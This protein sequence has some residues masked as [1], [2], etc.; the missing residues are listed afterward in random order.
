MNED[1]EQLV[2]D[3]LA[4]VLEAAQFLGLSRSKLYAEMDAGRLPYCKF[5]A[6]ARRIPW[7]AVR[8]FAEESLVLA[9]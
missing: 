8:A 6:R 5:G 3:G 1:R 4:K 9:C 7:R 2:E